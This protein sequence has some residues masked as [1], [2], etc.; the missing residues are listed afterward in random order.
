MKIASFLGRKQL[1]A[2]LMERGEEVRFLRPLHHRLGGARWQDKKGQ[3][4]PASGVPCG[5]LR[6][7][8]I[9]IEHISLSLQTKHAGTIPQLQY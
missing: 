2:Q 4:G 7:T 8:S 6:H 9:V 1:G 5:V 3:L